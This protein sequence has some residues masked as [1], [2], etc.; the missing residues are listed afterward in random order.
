MVGTRLGFSGRSVS[1][2]S[3][4]RLA[5]LPGRDGSRERGWRGNDFGGTVRVIVNTNHGCDLHAKP[6]PER[7]AVDSD[8]V[9]GREV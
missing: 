6:A 3:T 2:L 5:S 8:E 4:S 9:G 7:E 1:L